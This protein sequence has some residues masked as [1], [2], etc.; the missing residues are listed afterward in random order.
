MKKK[1]VIVGGSYGGIRAMQYLYKRDDIELI[2]IDQN[3]FHYL[4]PEAYGYVANTL[5][6]SDVIVDLYTL[7]ASYNVRFVQQEIADINF[8]TKKVLSSSMEVDYD[9][10][11]IATGAR[12]WFPDGVKNIGEFYTGGIKS[13][14][15]ALIFKQNFEQNMFKIIQSEGECRLDCRFS[16]VIGGAGL[17]GVETAAEMAWYAK[18]LFSNFG[19]LCSGVDVVL[20]ASGESILDNVD[21]YLVDVSTKRLKELGV[22][23][24]YNKKIIEVKKDSVV[25]DSGEILPKDFLIWTGGIIG[26]PLARK[27]DIKKNA[28]HF[29]EVDEYFRL[30]GK[31]DAFGIGDAVILKDPLSKKP[32]P[33]TSQMAEQSAQYVAK[34]IINLLENRDLNLKS[35]KMK[36]MF[37]A[38]G[39]NYGAGVIMGTIRIKGY[40]AH[41]IKQAIFKFYKMPLIKRCKKVSGVIK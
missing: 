11:I 12:T 21:K 2:L 28:R 26:S 29:L 14:P 18:K 1:I 34:N 41:L 37:V 9:Y 32:L 6:I 15:N 33:P 19:F 20:I 8:N 4:Q 3:P 7:C 23:V 13:I 30:S 40:I 38:L 36:G 24:L 16:I 17:S 22:R 39:G 35:L 5:N 31:N 25:L 27:L 10:L